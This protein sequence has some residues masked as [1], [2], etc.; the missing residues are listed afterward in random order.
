DVTR[1]RYTFHCSTFRGSR[2]PEALAR[3]FVLYP[4]EPFENTSSAWVEFSPV[5]IEVEFVQEGEEPSEARS[6]G[7][8]GYSRQEYEVGKR[9]RSERGFGRR[10]FA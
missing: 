1:E 9:R 3:D 4:P 8:P 2:T 10:V 7:L 6:A 5:G